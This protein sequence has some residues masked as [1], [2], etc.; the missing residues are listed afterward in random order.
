M[1]N[2][3]PNG[4]KKKKIVWFQKELAEFMYYSHW[5]HTLLAETVYS[6]AS[7]G[8]GAVCPGLLWRYYTAELLQL[9]CVSGSSLFTSW[10]MVC[11][12]IS[13]G[14]S[15]CEKHCEGE[16]V[17]V[18]EAGRR[19]AP[20]EASPK[21]QRPYNHYLE[22]KEDF[23]NEA[24][25]RIFRRSLL[26]A[27]LLV[28]NGRAELGLMINPQTFHSHSGVKTPNILHYAWLVMGRWIKS[29]AM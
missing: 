12:K 2:F 14:D 5:N 8:Q 21:L 7:Q 23:I 19:A 16:G 1:H 11:V 13:A 26:W 27:L 29:V 18:R 3:P 6:R 24:V 15:W 10:Q 4:Q 9:L 25:W 20:E 22:D 17:M 28:G